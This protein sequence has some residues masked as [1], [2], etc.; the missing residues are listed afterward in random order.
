MEA[1][2]FLLSLVAFHSI[3]RSASDDKGE[4]RFT[5]VY[6]RLSWIL[7]LGWDKHAVFRF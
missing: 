1:G 3:H 5:V 4:T 6:I 2:I 7:R